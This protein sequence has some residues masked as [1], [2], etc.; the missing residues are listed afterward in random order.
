MT[1]WPAGTFMSR[2]G[3]RAAERLL[4]LA[5]PQYLPA[6][7][8]LISQGDAGEQVMLLGPPPEGE[9]EESACVKVTSVLRNGTEAMFG[10]RLRGDLVG[11]L[12]MFRDTPPIAT[13]TSC[14][15]LSVRAFPHAVFES[16]LEEHPE[17]W[18]ALVRMMAERL[19][20][21]DRHRAEFFGYE[22]EARLARV[23]V[24]LAERHGTPTSQGVALGVRLSHTDL[25][26]LIGAR[27]DAVGNAIRRFRSEGL[28][29][30]GYRHVVIVDME[31]LNGVYEN[32]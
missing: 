10:I 9:N 30:S 16:F 18:R 19:E 14:S 26:K 8:V 22:V 25:G 23:L 15:P 7:R 31:R 12:S 6:N 32:A 17:A 2:I 20:W 28:L 3:A 13:V 27:T 5:P 1:D 21:A 11:E 4:S 24:D 29:E